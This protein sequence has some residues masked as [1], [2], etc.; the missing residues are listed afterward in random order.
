MIHRS[1]IKFKFYWNVLVSSIF[2]LISHIHIWKLSYTKKCMNLLI[3]FQRSL[4]SKYL[5]LHYYLLKQ[6][7]QVYI[8]KFNNEFLFLIKSSPSYLPTNDNPSL[9]CSKLQS[10]TWR[11]FHD[12][13]YLLYLT[14]G[15]ITCGCAIAPP[16]FCLRLH[17]EFPS[18]RR[19]Q[20]V[21]RGMIRPHWNHLLQRHSN[22]HGR[23]FL[24]VQDDIRG[25]KMEQIWYFSLHYIVLKN[26]HNK[27]LF[28]RCLKEQRSKQWSLFDFR[29]C[30]LWACER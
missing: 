25:R 27:M 17:V 6:Y 5:F 22:S 11:K 20:A 23:E 24:A 26:V 1:W 13:N 2:I 28:D 15:V 12:P 4:E 29:R 7:H 9:H 18:G 10:P 14:N 30:K 8:R 3:L 16:K 21:A 19:I